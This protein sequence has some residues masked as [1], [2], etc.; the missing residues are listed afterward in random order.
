M[1][2]FLVDIAFKKAHD[3]AHKPKKPKDE[4]DE[5]VPFSKLVA[6]MKEKT[7]VSPYGAG[8]ECCICL[9][10]YSIKRKPILLM[11]CGHTICEADLKQL[12]KKGKTHIKCPVCRKYT[13]YKGGC[14]VVV[15]YALME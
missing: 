3:E 12:L 13:A 11:G 15:N 10:K 8:K 1:P 5:D 6:K 7:A 14:G 4:D 9:E 2:S